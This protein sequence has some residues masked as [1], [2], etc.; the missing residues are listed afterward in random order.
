MHLR[1]I[2]C[3]FVLLISLKLIAM[4]VIFN[5][6]ELC[7]DDNLTLWSLLERQGIKPEGIAVAINNKIVRKVDWE[8]TAVSQG[9]KI[10]VIQAT[11]GG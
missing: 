11:Y 2:N 5:K 4:N 10:T 9:D 1:D 3:T 7:V 8:Q 6:Q